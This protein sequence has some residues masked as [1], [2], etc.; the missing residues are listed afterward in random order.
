METLVWHESSPYS[1]DKECNDYYKLTLHEMDNV[2]KHLQISTF[3][4][5]TPVYSRLCADETVYH[6]TK[7]A[8]WVAS[9]HVCCN[10]AN[11]FL[12]IILKYKCICITSSR[13]GVRI[14][15]S[16]LCFHFI[17][18]IKFHIWQWRGRRRFLKEESSKIEEFYLLCC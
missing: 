18:L 15:R 4:N 7:H 5:V 14:I 6:P 9:Q 3:D 10:G 8:V 2:I 17:A 12:F 16:L 1:C 11:F 13:N